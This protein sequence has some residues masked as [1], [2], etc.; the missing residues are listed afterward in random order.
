MTQYLA[1]ILAL[2]GACELIAAP[3]LFVVTNSKGA[4]EQA[5]IISWNEGAK[6]VFRRL[7]DSKESS[8]DFLYL[9]QQSTDV[10]R[11]PDDNLV[12][13]ENGDCLK[14][15]KIRVV[16]D[17]LHLLCASIRGEAAEQITLPI[18]ELRMVWWRNPRRELSPAQLRRQYLQK[19]LTKDQLVLANGEKVEG[20]FE[21][22]DQEKLDIDTGEIKSTLKTEQLA[23]L[24]LGNEKPPGGKTMTDSYRITTTAGDRITLSKVRLKDAMLAGEMFSGNQVR[25]PIEKVVNASSN[26]VPLLNHDFIS[27]EKNR[28]FSGAKS[29]VKPRISIGE[30]IFTSAGVMD[31]GLIL[32]GNSELKIGRIG[33]YKSLVMTL[34]VDAASHAMV[35]PR[36]V[37]TSGGKTIHTPLE[38]DANENK[39]IFLELDRF[40]EIVITQQ[41]APGVRVVISDAFLVP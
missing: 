6:T 19:R 36:L 3:P 13:L 16:D 29:V 32:D 12:W 4:G 8:F 27:L 18:L 11:I 31:D 20:I 37:F 26:V 2:I 40:Q 35:V 14:F 22:L 9:K 21:T 25:M 24:V 7:M 17:Q 39:T 5:T 28:W 33:K 10:P 41:A 30:E 1:L 23:F 34:G 38:I 15:E